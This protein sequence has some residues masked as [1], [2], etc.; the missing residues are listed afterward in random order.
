MSF[1]LNKNKIKPVYI[2]G[3]PVGPGYP[4]FL[5]AEAGVNH[6]GDLDTALRMIETARRAGVDAI[7]FQ[8]FKTESLVTRSAD[9]ADYQKEATGAGESQYDML[10]KLE[11]SFDDFR[12]IMKKCR[13]AG[14]MFLSTAFDK[15]SADFLDESGM[16]AFKIPSGDATNVPFL[17]HIAQKGKP[18]IVSTGMCSLAEVNVAVQC[19]KEAGN[20]QLVLLHCVSA[21]PAAPA[22][23]NLSAMRTLETA[24]HVPAGYSDHTVGIEISVASAALGAT[25]I[26]K[27]FTL[28]KHQ[29]G[30]DHASSIEPD[31]LERLVVSVRNVEQAIGDGHKRAASCELSTARA[32]RKSLVA[33]RDLRKG[34]VLADNMI[35]VKRPGTGLSP[36]ML[37]H[38]TGLRLAVDV[39]RDTPLTADMFEFDAKEDSLEYV[40]CCA[41][42]QN[43][44]SFGAKT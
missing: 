10:K 22:S 2:N 36:A 11:L 26:E 38:V 15:E 19:I 42:S 12:T 21:Y 14:I 3:R 24:F 37:E 28:D 29:S 1:F 9:K 23:V 44:R 20:R 6:N 7:K 18:M 13:E 43:D 5:I 4:V 25:V 39:S 35:V 31:E 40:E 8:T 30:P 27:H 33:I 16:E 41:S 17:R 32:A 34:D